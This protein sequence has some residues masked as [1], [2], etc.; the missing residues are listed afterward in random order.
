MNIDD[1]AYNFRQIS[2]V[3]IELILTNP[4]K[5]SF[6][7]IIQAQG[8]PQKEWVFELFKQKFKE[9]FIDIESQVVG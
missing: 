6:G 1:F 3:H 2:P 4:E 9:F 7:I 8:I 5:T